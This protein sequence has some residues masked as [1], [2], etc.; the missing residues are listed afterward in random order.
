MNA[1]ARAHVCVC[2]RACVRACVSACACVCVCVCVWCFNIHVVV[3]SSVGEY[4]FPLF[5]TPQKKAELI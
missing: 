4:V 3:L 2:V 1:R 5:F